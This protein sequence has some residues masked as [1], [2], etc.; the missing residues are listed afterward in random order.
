L[1][2]A[3]W[4]LILAILTESQLEIPGLLPIKGVFTV[5]SEACVLRASDFL[6]RYQNKRNELFPELR[7]LKVL[8]LQLFHRYLSARMY[9]C[10]FDKNMEPKQQ[11]RRK[12]IL[13]SCM[14]GITA[15]FPAAAFSGSKN[16]TPDS[17]Q[18]TTTILFQ[19]DSI[20]DGNRGRSS[21]PNHIMGHGY[22]FSVASRLGADFPER[23]LHFINRGIS[24][25]TVADLAARWQQDALALKPDVISILVGVNDI[26]SRFRN[27]NGSTAADF[28]VAYRQL[29]DNTRKA[30]PDALLVLGEPFILPVG[31][32]QENLEQWNAA[33]GEAQAVVEKLANDFG[34]VF[35]PYQQIFS[36]ACK[37]ASAAYWIWDGIHPTV[38]GHELMARTWMKNVGERLAVIRATN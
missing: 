9:Y 8:N 36:E 10:I 21:D 20:T 13:Q 34:A 5:K 18:K 28:Q 35:L 14:T 11:S 27:N 1:F 2:D 16:H 25:N 17:S 37:R 31:M 33:I 4:R 15:A 7:L 24:G 23:N 19:G 12:F 22:A 32:V 29:L 30:L 6:F 3:V 26:N 38:A